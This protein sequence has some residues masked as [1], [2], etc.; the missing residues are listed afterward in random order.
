MPGFDGDHLIEA[1]SGVV[2]SVGFFDTA[3]HA[4][5]STRVAA[6]WVREAKLETALPNPPKITNGEVLV[7]RTRE[8]VTA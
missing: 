8:L 6:D 7:H 4:E 2:S 3:A 5:E 1:G